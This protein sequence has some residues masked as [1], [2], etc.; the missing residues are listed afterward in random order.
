MSVGRGR[1]KD[2]PHNYTYIV[3]TR[4]RSPK[5][6][7]AFRSKEECQGVDVEVGAAGAELVRDAVGAAAA[8]AATAVRAG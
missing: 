3:A 8:A 7:V 2:C 6:P 4:T 1:L 5:T